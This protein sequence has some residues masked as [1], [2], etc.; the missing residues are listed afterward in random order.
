MKSLVVGIALFV[1]TVG[2]FAGRAS[3][4]EGPA[5]PSKSDEMAAWEQLA[6]PG[7][8]HQRLAALAGDWTVQ[9]KF[10]FEPGEPTETTSTAKMVSIL[11]GRYLREYITGDM[12]GMPFEGLGFQGYDNA[13][14]TYVGV[15]MDN[16]GT[17]MMRISGAFD[18]ASK[19]WT[20]QGVMNGPGAEEMKSRH[21]MKIVSDRELFSEMWM[22]GPE[23]EMKVM[24]LKYSRKGSG[25]GTRT[26]TGGPCR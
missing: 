24:E 14:Q 5:A 6:K 12:H 13:T 23:G 8:E 21:T 4:D 7:P 11:G 19:T 26:V 3:T 1:G 18:E 10:W 16:M 25:T 22:T 15:W 20:L 2:F 9:G 17:G